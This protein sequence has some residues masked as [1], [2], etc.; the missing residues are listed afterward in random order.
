MSNDLHLPAIGLGTYNLRGRRDGRA[1]TAAVAAGYRLIDSAF[2]YENEAIVAEG[3]ARAVT[4]GHAARADLIVTSKVPGRHFGRDRALWA[5]EESA[6]RMRPIGPIDLYLIHWPNPAQDLY[7]DTWRALI[8][9]REQG[10]VRHIGVSNFLPEHIQRLEDETGVLPAVNQV[11]C[12][13]RFPNTEQV[14]HD[15][16][17][18]ILTEAWSPIGRSGEVLRDP[19]VL[20][21][22]QAHGI[23]PAQA[24]L[25][26]HVARGVTPI[27]KSSSPERQAENLAAADVL[28]AP[29]EVAA[30]TALGRSDGRLKGQDPAVYEEM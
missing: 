28:L 8:E 20:A 24:V 21:V 18:G 17:R 2:S 16:S 7:V 9:A 30:I 29:E 3:V 13:P 12:H 11:E 1:V 6:A 4:E 10:L 19:V 26:W 22:A 15:A 14:A 23:T 5:V 27:P 25:A